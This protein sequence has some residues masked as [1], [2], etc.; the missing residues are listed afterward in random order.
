[1]KKS[2]LKNYNRLLR[3]ENE[4]QWELLQMAENMLRDDCRCGE[5]KPLQ[6]ENN[7]LVED[8]NDLQAD[9]AVDYTVY[10]REVRRA[11]KKNDELIRDI[12]D[13]QADWAADHAE[14]RSNVIEL[15]TQRTRESDLAVRLQSRIS[16]LQEDIKSLDDHNDQYREAVRGLKKDKYDMG[17]EI[18]RLKK[19]LDAAI[20]S[21][22]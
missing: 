21:Q 10:T 13:L 8:L 15:V 12:R 19:Q 18:E 14:H 11:Y 20:G 17:V 3:E 16:G 7:G 22:R 4:I 5:I 2:E 1:M 9:S 6:E